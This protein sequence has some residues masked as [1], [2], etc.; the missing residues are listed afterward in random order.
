M[1]LS[2]AQHWLG[3]PDEREFLR[4]LRNNFLPLFPRLVSQ[5]QFNR[6]AR[7]LC[8]LIHA[9]RQHLVAQRCV[10]TWSHRDASA[11]GRTDGHP[12][13]ALPTH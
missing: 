5:G 1:T 2:I 7:N 11:P 10:S 9:M 13:Y 6:R 4:V 8:W 3:I 12:G